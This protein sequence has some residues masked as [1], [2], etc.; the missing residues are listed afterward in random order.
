MLWLSRREK[1]GRENQFWVS[2][3]D[4]RGGHCTANV[5]FPGEGSQLWGS[6]KDETERNRTA[7]IPEKPAILRAR[8][9]WDSRLFVVWEGEREICYCLAKS[10]G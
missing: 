10:W 8:L 4:E 9:L 3:E 7:S 5:R 6:T 1:A 2:A